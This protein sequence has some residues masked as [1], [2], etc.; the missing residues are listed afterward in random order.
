MFRDFTRQIIKEGIIDEKGEELLDLGNFGLFKGR[1]KDTLEEIQSLVESRFV[2]QGEIIYSE[3]DSSGEIFLIRR[4][5][6]RTML[7]FAGRKSVHLS[8]LGQNNFFLEFS[9]LEGIPHYTDAIA[10]SDTDLYMIS[11]EAFDQFSVHHKKASFHF[12]QSLATV[13]AERLRVPRSELG[14]EYDV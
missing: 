13:L 1:N 9:F 12:M 14:A 3:G 6:V 2:K 8:T 10:S 5:F 7:P 4:G 11:R